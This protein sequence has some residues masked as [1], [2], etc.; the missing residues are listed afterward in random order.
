M[1]PGGPQNFI[2]AGAPGGVN[3]G[4]ATLAQVVAGGS[5][6]SSVPGVAGTEAS[7]L[8]PGVQPVQNPF[9][10]IDLST[11]TEFKPR[12]KVVAL[13]QDPDTMEEINL[14]A[15]KGAA[16]PQAGKN[17]SDSSVDGAPPATNDGVSKTGADPAAASPDAQSSHPPSGKTSEKVRSIVKLCVTF[18]LI[19]I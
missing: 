16:L 2:A 13:L 5:N 11:L 3:P 12:K 19:L 1:V 18:D 15:L 7:P 10:Q 8:N 4:P 9:N 6:V 17:E 14:D